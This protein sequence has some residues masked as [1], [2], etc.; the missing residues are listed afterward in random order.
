M[1]RSTLHVRHCN[2]FVTIIFHN[3]IN[4][5]L[6]QTA[7]VAAAFYIKHEIEIVDLILN[8][9]KCGFESS[10]TSQIYRYDS[11]LNKQETQKSTEE[12]DVDDE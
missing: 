11:S 8:Q 4:I 1:Y 5:F 2:S 6:P 9:A 3:Y 7:A 10:L 12:K